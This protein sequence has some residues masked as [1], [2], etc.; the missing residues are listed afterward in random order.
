[1]RKI[2]W[3]NNG[4]ETS[5]LILIISLE[6]TKVST[7]G[8]E[9]LFLNKVH[10]YSFLSFLTNLSLAS[11]CRINA[12]NL[13]EYARVELGKS[14]RAETTTLDVSRMAKTNV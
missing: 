5:V 10:K 8:N 1:M 4:D 12:K 6:Q 2:S 7:S 14:W 9:S 3:C 13:G 11:L